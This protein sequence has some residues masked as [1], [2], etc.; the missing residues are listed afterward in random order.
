MEKDLN[1]TRELCRRLSWAT[2]SEI[3]EQNSDSVLTFNKENRNDD[4]DNNDANVRAISNADF[5]VFY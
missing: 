1:L 5:E 4:S 3:Q 2:L